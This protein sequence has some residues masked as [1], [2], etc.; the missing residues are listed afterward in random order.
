MVYIVTPCSRPENL[1][2]IK[3]S[4]PEECKW[5]VAYDDNCDTEWM[6]DG[7]INCT[8]LGIRD[9][10]WGNKIRNW[11]LDNY[12]FED[13]DWL[14]YLDDD[15]IIKEDWYH[16]INCYLNSDAA[17]LT[18]GQLYGTGEERLDPTGTPQSFKID[19]ACFMVNWK[20]VKEV[21]WGDKIE[22]DGQYAQDCASKGRLIRLQHY[23][24]Y[25]NYITGK[26]HPTWPDRPIRPNLNV[27][28]QPNGNYGN[29]FFQY[30]MMRLFA[31]RCN[32]TPRLPIFEQHLSSFLGDMLNLSGSDPEYPETCLDTT[33][34][35]QYDLI[36]HTWH[37]SDYS[38]ERNYLHY[39][40]GEK[41]VT[42]DVCLQGYFQHHDIY[43]N[44]EQ[45]RE[46]FNIPKVTVKDELCINLRLDG[47]FETLG[48]VARPNGIL[49]LLDKLDF[50]KLT[51]ITDKFVAGYINKFAQYEPTVVCRDRSAPN[52]D[53]ADLMQFKRL[54]VTNSTFSWWAAYL[55]NAETVYVPNDFGVT[56]RDFC[57]LSKVPG[58]N[59]I[60]YKVTY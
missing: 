19:T 40:N 30:A 36:E 1:L 32:L 60:E 7:V 31:D 6:L 41:E 55:G 9:A 4:I 33:P 10:H 56:Y 11:V 58:K 28:F 12:E 22:S 21:R 8:G 26:L 53:F 17:I 13:G 23:L 42:E 18:W 38:N 49:K 50:N 20:H 43:S 48:L 39:W 2:Q 37:D 52:E 59:T 24:C 16:H 5:I 44:Y 54:I 27:T 46:F 47:D 25:Y 35:T 15:N 51:I 57:D 3:K 45:V 14:Y 34:G 29:L